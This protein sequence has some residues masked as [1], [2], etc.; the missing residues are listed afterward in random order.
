MFEPKYLIR[1]DDACSTMKQSNWDE[2]EKILDD[3]SIKPIVSIIPENEDKSLNYSHKNINFWEK[4]R[5]WQAK[6]WI[7]GLHGYKHNLEKTDFKSILNF[8]SSSEFT[9][10]PI[11]VQKTKLKNALKI[12]FEQNIVPKVWVAPKH[13]FDKNTLSALNEITDIKIISDGIAIKH[14]FSKDFTWLPVQLWN[15]RQMPFG[16]WT[17][18]LHPNTMNDFDFQNMKKFIKKNCHHFIDLN[19]E[20]LPFRKV[21]LLDKIFRLFFWTRR[22]IKIHINNKMRN[23]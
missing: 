1:L 20:I 8:Y 17:F 21:N 22:K 11:E 5:N 10:L 23:N 16:T 2:V 13:T 7:I 14:Y 15:F 4:A 6:N 12:F 18:C 3:Y 9:G 19:N